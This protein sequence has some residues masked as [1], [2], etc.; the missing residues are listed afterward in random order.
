MKKGLL[1][2]ALAGVFASYMLSSCSGVF[3]NHTSLFSSL[4]D[5]DV[6]RQ[7]IPSDLF[8]YVK[9]SDATFR[10]S[11][12]HDLLDYMMYERENGPGY[13]CKIAK[14][15]QDSTE[16][17][18]C[19]F[20]VLE[21]DLFLH[22]IEFEYNVPAGMCD[23]FSFQTHWHY[24]KT[25]GP[26]PAAVCE[27]WRPGE[28]KDSPPVPVFYPGKCDSR[29]GEN[30]YTSRPDRRENIKELCN[31]YIP[32]DEKDAKHCCLGTYKLYKYGT[33]NEDPKEA[34]WGGDMRGCIGGLGR[35]A[36]EYFTADGF[37]QVLIRNATSGLRAKYEIPAIIEILDKRVKDSG[38]IDRKKS[39][40]TANH[41]IGIEDNTDRPSFYQADP[42]LS[43]Q[44]LPEG[45]PYIS[46]ACEDKGR[47]VKHRIHLIIREWN[48]RA[49][50]EEFKSGGTGDPDVAEKEGGDCDYYEQE[51]A[52]LSK[53]DDCNDMHD[54]DDFVAT[55]DTH[56][57]LEYKQ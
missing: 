54:A 6:G 47:E 37:P 25:A 43:T 24:N 39:F 50:F 11:Q 42:S 16:D 3:S 18:Y 51:D 32:Q 15:E 26:G 29:D 17:L 1:Y 41:W 53:E 34:S 23:Y 57:D 13:D 46:F 40:V 52:Y 4:P 35:V 9:I 19:M 5:T 22:Q 55:G 38:I 48:T 36:W 44:L 56:P 20:E 14:N 2:T 30:H 21:G 49:E 7:A 8:F 12:G 10:G 27:S 28:E 31:D 45:H 33:N